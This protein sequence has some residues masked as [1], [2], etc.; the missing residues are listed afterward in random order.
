VKPVTP[1]L[2]ILAVETSA[3]YCSVA[4]RVGAQTTSADEL[5]GQ[6]H[7]ELLLPMVHD[8][9]EAA[10]L[11]VGDLDAVAFG[12]GPGSFT[13]LRIGCGVVQGL[14]FVAGCPVVPVGSLEALAEACDGQ[15]VLVCSDARMGQIYHGAFERDKQM[16]KAILPPS[17]CD[18]DRLPAL[19]G[20][21][22]LGCGSGFERYREALIAKY[23]RQLVGV[24]SKVFARARDIAALAVR[25]LSVGIGVSSTE[26]VPV[27][28]RDKVALT[29][30]EQK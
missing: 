26:A 24:N 2:K 23:Q 15:R 27:Y 10:R 22:W 21:G 18:P 8:L 13:G 12:A 14:A 20:A 3:E 28:V 9:L 30:E 11:R 4:L 5:A 7:S 6:K 19:P 25:Y 16:W 29:M 17:V 1:S